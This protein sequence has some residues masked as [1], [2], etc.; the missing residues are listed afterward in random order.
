MTLG[1]FL[2][3][4]GPR[5][6]V[7]GNPRNPLQCSAP[8]TYF[9]TSGCS[10]EFLSLLAGSPVAGLRPAGLQALYWLSLKTKERA[11]NQPQS[12]QQFN[13]WEILRVWSKWVLE[14]ISHRGWQTNSGQDT[15]AVFAPGK[16]RLPLIGGII[17]GQLI[18]CQPRGMALLAPQ[19]KCLCGAEV[20]PLLD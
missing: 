15:A 8:H 17:S 6:L 9:Q 3:T 19:A 16:G 11:Q 2:S 14:S 5:V 20:F 13:R 18:D 7:D 1:G 10:R 12:H 4:F